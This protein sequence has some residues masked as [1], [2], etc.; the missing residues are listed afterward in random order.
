MH[1]Q[2]LAIAKKLRQAELNTLARFG[3]RNGQLMKQARNLLSDIANDRPTDSAALVKLVRL[4]DQ[5][6]VDTCEA[7]ESTYERFTRS[8]HAE[9]DTLCD[10]LR[11]VL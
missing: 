6:Q 5:N 3:K 1:R 4:L 2:L 10:E 9:L 11:K 8:H 7:V